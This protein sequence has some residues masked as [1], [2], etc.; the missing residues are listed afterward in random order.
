MLDASGTSL[1]RVELAAKTTGKLLLTDPMVGGVSWSAH[2]A[3]L[4]AWR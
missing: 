3:S 4:C 1:L 2:P